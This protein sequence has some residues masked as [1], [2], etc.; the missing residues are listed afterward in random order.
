MLRRH[1]RWRNWFTGETVMATP[2]EDPCLD[3]QEV[4]AT[5]GGLPFAVLVAE[6]E[7]A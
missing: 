7:N 2:G 5:A 3:L 1:P 4:F 6:T